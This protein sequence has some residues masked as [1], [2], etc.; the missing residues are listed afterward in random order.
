MNS[1]DTANVRFWLLADIP[2]PPKLLPLLPPKIALILHEQDIRF[3]GR[4]AQVRSQPFVHQG[5]ELVQ[6]GGLHFNA[7]EKV[8][9]G[10]PERPLCATQGIH[11][12]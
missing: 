2:A 12:F 6:Q 10:V 11:S 4:A 1:A 8:G 3:K 7:V 5:L 9:H